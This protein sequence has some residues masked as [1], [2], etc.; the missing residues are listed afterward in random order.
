M[1][2]QRPHQLSSSD[3]RSRRREEELSHAPPISGAG[4]YMLWESGS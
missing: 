4:N 2:E 3:D 1:N